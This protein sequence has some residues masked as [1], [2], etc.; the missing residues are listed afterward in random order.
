MA[1]DPNPL[2]PSALPLSE[3]IR[4]LIEKWRKRGDLCDLLLSGAGIRKHER[5]ELEGEARGARL[6][7]DE[8][9][10]LLKE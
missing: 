1:N 8:L 9:S 4:Q 2:T 10:A 5:H 6:C 3:Q 7:A